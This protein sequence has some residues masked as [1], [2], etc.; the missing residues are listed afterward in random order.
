M[1]LLE[2]HNIT[3]DVR[4]KCLFTIDEARVERQQKELEKRASSNDT[5][6]ARLLLETKI[7]EV[8]G[9]LSVAPSEELESEFQRLI[10]EKKQ[11]RKNK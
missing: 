7:A 9:K 1:S 2:L 3:Y 4:D 11:L 8:L 10:R 5:R 6:Q